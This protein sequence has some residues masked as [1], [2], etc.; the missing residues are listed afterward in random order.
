[1]YTPVSETDP[2]L[3]SPSGG[4]DR[5]SPPSGAVNSLRL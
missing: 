3:M 1:M 4:K 5:R 2:M